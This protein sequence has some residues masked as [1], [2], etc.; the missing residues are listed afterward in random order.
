MNAHSRTRRHRRA[1][2][3]VSTA[4]LLA[5]LC[6]ASACA[7]GPRPLSLWV[8]STAD[9]NKTIDKQASSVPIR[10]FQLI[11]REG[12]DSATGIDL[13]GEAPQVGQVTWSD[14]DVFIA[15]RDWIQLEIKP[16]VCYLG[17]V[18]DF[19]GE[20]Q[21]QREVMPIE[22]LDISKLSFDQY[23]LKAAFREDDEPPPLEGEAAT[24]SGD[25]GQQ[26]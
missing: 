4:A 3:P 11:D 9:L 6:I 5:L 21:K 18:G 20:G 12:F 26:P 2:S 7:S 24:P 1:P 23:S 19:N 15:R 16:K 14:H 22:S 10:I 8:E 13:L 25:D 17:I